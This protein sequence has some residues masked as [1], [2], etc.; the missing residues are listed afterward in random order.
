MLK[1]KEQEL[2]FTVFRN[3]LHISTIKDYVSI[4]L[5]HMIFVKAPITLLYQQNT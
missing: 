1:I 2:G 3:K 4:Y 5:I